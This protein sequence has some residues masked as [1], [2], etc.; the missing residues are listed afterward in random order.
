MSIYHGT[1]D[2]ASIENTRVTLNVPLDVDVK[3]GQS[4]ILIYDTKYKL[5]KRNKVK[6][7]KSWHN[8]RGYIIHLELFFERILIN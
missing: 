6:K 3:V 8:F 2:V 4:V 1:C 5:P 7:K